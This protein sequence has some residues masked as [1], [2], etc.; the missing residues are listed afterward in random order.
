[1]L[2][3]G[4]LVSPANFSSH[5]G[6]QAALCEPGVNAVVQEI[7]A[8]ELVKNGLGINRCDLA[9]FGAQDESG[10]AQLKEVS[11]RLLES[12]S[13]CVLDSSIVREGDSASFD[14]RQLAREINSNLS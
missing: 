1:M 6:L 5:S 13:D 14:V 3:D 2:I 12:V 11:R 4:N 10:D 8:D 7:S 9:V